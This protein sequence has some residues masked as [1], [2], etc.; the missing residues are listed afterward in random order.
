[1]WVFGGKDEDNN[2]LNDLWKLDLN[3][4]VWTQINVTGEKPIER[5][6]HAC[7]I[8]EEYMVVF[9]G[10]YEITKELNDFMM[11]D[12]KANRWLTFFEDLHS[13][14]KTNL[15][16]QFA[17]YEASPYGGNTTSTNDNKFNN[18]S[19]SKKS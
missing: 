19:M 16:N 11:Y 13:P 17:N 15:I 10:I 6:G 14:V 8:Y 1:M 2:K 4:Y 5:S 18:G 12:F 7:D 3:I 9:G